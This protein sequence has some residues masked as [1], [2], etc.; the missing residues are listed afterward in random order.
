[1][2]AKGW[3]PHTTANP[4]LEPPLLLTH[5]HKP[6]HPR[7]GCRCCRPGGLI[8]GRRWGQGGDEAAGAQL[9]LF[10]GPGGLG[11]SQGSWF[12]FHLPEAGPGLGVVGRAREERGDGHLLGLSQGAR[13]P[14]PGGTPHLLAGLVTSQAIHGGEAEPLLGEE[15]LLTDS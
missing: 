2:S 1:M 11:V 3:G 15:P 7:G 14:D 8:P 10:I 4:L 9:P 12:P 13:L 5:Q 6:Q